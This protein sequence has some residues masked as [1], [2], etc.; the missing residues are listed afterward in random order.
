MHVHVFTTWKDMFKEC[1]WRVHSHYRAIRSRKSVHFHW[2]DWGIV[3]AERMTAA[4]VN[5]SKMSLVSGV[6]VEV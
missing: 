6:K 1:V 3:S 4:R 2:L 5:A